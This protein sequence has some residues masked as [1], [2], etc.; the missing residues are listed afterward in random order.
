[1][2]WYPWLNQIY[3]QIIECHQNN[4]AHHS[5]LIQ[6][7][8]GM[9][10]DLLVWA[11][12]R[13][14]MCLQQRGIKSC[15]YCHG[16]QLMT[17]HNHP[18][19]YCLKAEEGK[20][21]IGIDAIRDVVEQCYHCAQQG[22]AKVIWVQNTLQLTEEAHNALLK[23]IEEPPNNCWFFLSCN[24]YSNLPLTLRSRC[25][26]FHIFPPEESYSLQWLQQKC[27][28]SKEIL[29]IALKLSNG[30]PAAAFKFIESNLFEQR[31]ILYETLLNALDKNLL[32]LVPVLN[33][34]NVFDL[35]DWLISLLVDVIK[36]QQGAI[37]WI[38]NSDY[39]DIIIKLSKEFN[40]LSLHK[41][42]NHWIIGRKQIRLISTFEREIILTERVLVWK[43]LLIRV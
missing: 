18:D 37:K 26:L 30:A 34:K 8:Y 13:W 6:A 15:N 41:S 20:V 23:V 22:G 36:V 21:T 1:M 38:N 28:S 2:N 42:I 31:K 33:K 5:I 27:S 29:H 9:G 35:L 43:Q 25:I 19:W 11:I 12:S 39:L 32:L 40:N 24:D 7:I 14:L 3:R 17:A 10:D 4:R 16:C